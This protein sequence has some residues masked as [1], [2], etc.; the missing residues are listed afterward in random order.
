MELYP[1]AVSVIMLTLPVR[2]R[3]MVW[4]RGAC[5]PTCQLP[6]RVSWVLARVSALDG[7]GDGA[8]C[9]EQVG[10]VIDEAVKPQVVDGAVDVQKPQIGPALIQ[11][12]R[13]QPAPDVDVLVEVVNE[14][15]RLIAVGVEV[16]NVARR[17]L[18]TP[19]P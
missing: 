6:K 11:R 16:G 9:V 1:A 18:P 12:N 19:A 13:A 4:V 3:L 15:E 7:E 8:V 17:I 10:I 2:S 5:R 14:L